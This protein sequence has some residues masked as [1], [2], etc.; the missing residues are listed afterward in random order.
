MAWVA[1]H[2]SSSGG[3]FGHNG[4]LGYQP[5]VVCVGMDLDAVLRRVGEKNLGRIRPSG[6][7]KK[8]SLLEIKKRGR[9]TP[10]FFYIFLMGFKGK[11]VV[12]DNSSSM[13]FLRK[14][15]LGFSNNKLQETAKSLHSS[16]S[17]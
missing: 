6:L 15:L 3:C 16:I 11:G 5:R 13:S 10:S 12:W 2:A 7:T 8:V 4:V 9:F 14:K 17:E 1:V